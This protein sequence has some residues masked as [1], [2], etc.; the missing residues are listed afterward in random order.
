MA[1]KKTAPAAPKSA[2][3]APAKPK[4][5]KLANGN[6]MN[7]AIGEIANVPAKDVNAW[8]AKGWTKAD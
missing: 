4:F 5:V 1:D 8:T 2:P 7:G 6:R 3:K